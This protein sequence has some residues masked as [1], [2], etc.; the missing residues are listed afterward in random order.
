MEK[1]EP[2]PQAPRWQILRKIHPNVYILRF[3]SP[4]FSKQSSELNMKT[5][6]NWVLYHFCSSLA[7]NIK[8]WICSPAVFILPLQ[9]R[10]NSL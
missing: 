7:L 6:L 5:L 9:M 10:K 8:S 4:P 2:T 3:P 1:S